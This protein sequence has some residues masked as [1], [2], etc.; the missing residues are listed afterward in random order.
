MRTRHVSGMNDMKLFVILFLVTPTCIATCF[1]ILGY[2]VN[3]L[4]KIDQ[5]LMQ[6]E[7]IIS[8]IVAVVV[9]YIIH[10]KGELSK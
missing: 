2:V 1:V 8:I 4:T 3:G 9:C 7:I 5:T 10:T 6:I